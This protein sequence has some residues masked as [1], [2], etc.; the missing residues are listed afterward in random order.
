M[1]KK[2]F[3]LLYF[4]ILIILLTTHTL[5]QNTW[6][7]SDNTKSGNNVNITS[8]KGIFYDYNAIIDTAIVYDTLN[9]FML[10][11]DRQRIKTDKI[12]GG[13]SFTDYI[14]VWRDST[15][16]IIY[17]GQFNVDR[18]GWTKLGE[19]SLAW[20]SNYG[21]SLR[22]TMTSTG[23]SVYQKK[24]ITSGTY[25]VRASVR[26]TSYSSSPCKFRVDMTG[27]VYRD[28]D[29]TGVGLKSIDWIMKSTVDNEVTVSLTH[30]SL[31]SITVYLDSISIIPLP[32][33][34]PG[35][36]YERNI[37]NA[38]DSTW[39]WWQY[40]GFWKQND[41]DTVWSYSDVD[42]IYTPKYFDCQPN[43][44]DFADVTSA[45]L[46]TVI[47]SNPIVMSGFT[48]D[49]VR[50][51]STTAEYRIGANGSWNL[52]TFYGGSDFYV[53]NG[54]SVWLRVTSSEEYFT[55]T[56]SNLHVYATESFTITWNVT[57]KLPTISTRVIISDDAGD[58]THRE[59]TRLAFIAGYE[60]AG[61]TWQDSIW[62]YNNTLQNALIQGSN[63]STEIV[64]RSTTGLTSYIALAESYAPDI[65]TFMPAGS[66]SHI[67]V[68]NSGG[69]LPDLIVTGAGDLV[70]ETG[71]DVEF[72]SLDPITNEPDLS[73]FSNAYIAG[74]MMY[75]ADTLNVSLWQI[76]DT[77]RTRLGNTW[78]L[79]NGYGLVS[80][81]LV[82]SI[83]NGEPINPTSSFYLVNKD[84]GKI[85]LKNRINA[86]KF[87]E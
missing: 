87:K 23:N 24:P 72:Y 59:N 42:S 25:R 60:C 20:S 21:G 50:M 78:S 69:V 73:S 3:G 15:K 1:I 67:Q 12:S 74:M 34:I 32:D 40:Y 2:Y 44:V 81:S 68:Y 54:D 56:Y 49:S 61:G 63:L 22:A 47:V 29:I 5:A 28:Y 16:E 9:L 51:N 19:Y 31:N 7:T 6:K 18:N 33:S 75:L 46:N 62:V 14:K 71:Y 37:V 48:C 38:N 13:K 26:T 52:G 79:E 27:G 36:Y 55:T 84:G 83:V 45:E 66:N 41:G 65:M 4:V 80:C 39:Y 85:L 58:D 35:R 77:L 53:S 70:N 11:G 82:T 43:V 30:Q 57:T 76:R 64:I 10:T 8:S 86:I 17:N